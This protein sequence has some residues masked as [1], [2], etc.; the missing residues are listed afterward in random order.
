MQCSRGI[1]VE[2]SRA[3]YGLVE[4]AEWLLAQRYFEA[5][6]EMLRKWSCYMGRVAQES[7][8]LLTTSVLYNTIVYTT[9]NKQFLAQCIEAGNPDPEETRL[10]ISTRIDLLG[11][12]CRS[13]LEGKNR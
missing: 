4:H 12:L 1:V 7:W 5:S 6:V 8:P 3:A 13:T 11:L 10:S 2:H 9:W